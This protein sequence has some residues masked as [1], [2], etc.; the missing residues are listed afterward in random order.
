[1]L[2]YDRMV[3]AVR[4]LCVKVK[5]M[6]KLITFGDVAQETFVSDQFFQIFPQKRVALK[7]LLAEEINR[8]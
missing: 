6:K 4:K 1:M 8:A 7:E 3:E 2:G 5:A